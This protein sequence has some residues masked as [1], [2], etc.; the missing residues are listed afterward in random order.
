MVNQREYHLLNFLLTETEPTDPFSE[1]PSKRIRFE[2]LR[3]SAYVKSAYKNVT[4]RTFFRELTR[5]GEMGFI[6]FERAADNAD[7]IIE[8]DLNAVGKY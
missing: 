7:A 2:D 4:T 5:L 3:N 1:S 8:L 6:R